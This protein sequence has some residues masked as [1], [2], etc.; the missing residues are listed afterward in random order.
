MD[1]FLNNMI[2]HWCSLKRMEKYY[3]DERLKTEEVIQSH[4]QNHNQWK[5]VGTIDLDKLK[6]RM[7]PRRKWNQHKLIQIKNENDLSGLQF[8]FIV[9][10]KEIRLR[11]DYLAENDP[12]LWDKLQRALRITPSKPYFVLTEKNEK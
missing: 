2:S 3:A 11:S 5:S 9:E 7:T 12:M 6:I 4:L 1:K 10:Y 8:P